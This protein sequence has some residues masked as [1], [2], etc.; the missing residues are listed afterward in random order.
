MTALLLLDLLQLQ[1]GIRCID[2][3][4]L[5]VEGEQKQTWTLLAEA[6]YA[7]VIGFEPLKE[8][9]D[10]LNSAPDLPKSIKYLPYAIGDG[11]THTLRVTNL[12]MT[13]SL[14]EP[15]RATLDLFSNLGEVTQVVNHQ[16][17]ETQRLD[18]IA[19]LGR[20]DFMKLDIQGAELMALQNATNTLK[21]TSVIQ[22]E[23]EFVELYENQPLFA[24]IDAF[25]RS[26]GFCFLKFTYTLGRPFRPLVINNDPNLPISQ[27]LWGDAVYVKDFRLRH[28]WE[29]RILQSAAYILHEFYE[30]F[31]LAH[32]FVQ[33]LDRRHGTN[34]SSDYLSNFLGISSEST[35]G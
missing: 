12:P 11:K 19:D 10:Q 17:V 28:Q 18:D 25:L 14:Y 20:I 4:A 2:C 33:E 29:D 5:A 15:A 31:D 3:G 34:R 6:G 35:S 26:Q 13:S 21:G 9:C 23:V 8:A 22:C 32:L 1:D 7:E 24:D 16:D 30:G 27:T